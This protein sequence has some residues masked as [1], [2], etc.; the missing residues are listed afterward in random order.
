MNDHP[1]TDPHT[2]L[3]DQAMQ[4]VALITLAVFLLAMADASV[5]YFSLR[6]PLWQ[7]FLGVSFISVPTLGAWLFRQV[8][9][10]RIRIRSLRWAALR[11]VL[12]LVMWITYYAALPL[13][14]LSVAAVAIYTAPLFIALFAAWWGNERLSPFG[15]L[16]VVLGFAGVVIVL[17]PGSLGF[18][19][20]ALLPVVAAIFY[21]MAMVVTRRH[22][23]GEH[24]VVLAFALNVVFLLASCGGAVASQVFTQ[25]AANV[26]FLLATWQPLG[27]HEALFI[28]AYALVLVMINISTARAYQLAP[29]ALVGTF[30][31]AYLIFACFWGYWLFDEVPTA[32]TWVGMLL[33]LLAG[34]LVARRPSR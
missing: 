5:K 32:H 31:Y 3:D 34:L 1:L 11:S 30:D 23:R 27:V 26:P 13:I 33:I 28:T 8:R 10:R 16:A 2:A 29:A 19:L 6:M 24:P 12:L 7:L 14:P 15:W 9:A 25:A 21:A 18:S 20:A 17:E 22:C 4:G